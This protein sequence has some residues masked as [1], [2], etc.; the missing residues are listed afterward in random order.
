MTEV[1][2]CACCEFLRPF[3][4]NNLVAVPRTL[5]VDFDCELSTNHNTNTTRRLWTLHVSPFTASIKRSA[6]RVDQLSLFT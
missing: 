3:G 6:A 4:I 2:A 5:R 1:K